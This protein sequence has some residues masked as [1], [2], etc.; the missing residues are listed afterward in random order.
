[1]TSTRRDTESA[2][3]TLAFKI[4]AVRETG[5]FRHTLTCAGMFILKGLAASDLTQFHLAVR[6]EL[7][8]AHGILCWL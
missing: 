1:M 8:I 4:R 2:S 7:Y 6:I 3:A 5:A